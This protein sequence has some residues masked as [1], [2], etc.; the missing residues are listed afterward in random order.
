MRRDKRTHRCDGPGDEVRYDHDHDTPEVEH[1]VAEED[2]EDVWRL[3]CA[4]AR[5]VHLEGFE[6]G[7]GE[8]R[9]LKQQRREP[10]RPLVRHG[11]NRDAASEVRQGWQRLNCA[12]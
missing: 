5:A 8:E 10:V 9:E 2:D 4:L 11:V 3:A 12:M 6:D 7:E 1:G